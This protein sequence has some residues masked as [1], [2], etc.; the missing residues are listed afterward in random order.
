MLG[1]GGSRSACSWPTRVGIF[2]HAEVTYRG[3]AVGQVTGPAAEPGRR[4]RRLRVEDSATHPADTAAW[5]QPLGIGEQTVDLRPTTP[6]G[7]PG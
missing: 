4:D 7:V 5:S 6:A 2:P 1:A 3:V